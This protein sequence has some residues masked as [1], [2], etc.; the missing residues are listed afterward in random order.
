MR[1]ILC[2]VATLS[3]V[4]MFSACKKEYV[5]VCVPSTAGIEGIPVKY[6]IED[7][8]RGAES[9]YNEYESNVTVLEIS[10]EV[11]CHLQ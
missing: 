6:T 1:K 10:S 8:K 4:A 3:L 5:C 11:N 7:S 9:Q 2:I